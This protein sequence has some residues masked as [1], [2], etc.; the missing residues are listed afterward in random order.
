M[1]VIIGV[2]AALVVLG[3]VDRATH[4]E[5]RQPRRYYQVPSMIYDREEPTE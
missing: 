3:E 4:P 1:G 2:I 5:Q